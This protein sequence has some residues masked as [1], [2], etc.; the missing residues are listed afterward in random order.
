MSSSTRCF[1][2]VNCSV[3]GANSNNHFNGK[4]LGVMGNREMQ[5]VRIEFLV[6][7]SE[8]HKDVCCSARILTALT[9]LLAQRLLVAQIFLSIEKMQR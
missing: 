7:R 4:L 3:F 6:Q 8:V 2:I 5:T 9:S 1:L